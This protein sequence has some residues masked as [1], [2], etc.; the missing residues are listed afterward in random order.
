MSALEQG[1][2]IATSRSKDC[3]V[4]SRTDRPVRVWSVAA[5]ALVSHLL[6]PHGLWAKTPVRAPHRDI[7]HAA[8]CGI[9][10][11]KKDYRRALEHCNAA[12]HVRPDDDESLS[13]RGSVHFALGN[14]EEAAARRKPGAARTYF[15][16]AL[17]HAARKDHVWAIADYD[18]A[19]RLM[20][21]LAI[22]YNNR[23]HQFEATGE[24]E[25][26]IADYRTALRLAPPLA[27]VIQ[28]NLRRLGVE[29]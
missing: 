8:A 21:D 28:H 10:Q 1:Y 9:L 19:I 4:A 2:A 22:A 12:L 24:M 29:P 11:L 6:L 25:R 26:A 14:Y 15:N 13:N 17:V 7:D 3:D 5:F 23:A 27:A 18:E 16:R 20:P